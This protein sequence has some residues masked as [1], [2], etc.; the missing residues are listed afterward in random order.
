MSNNVLEL[1]RRAA[2]LNAAVQTRYEGVLAGRLAMKEYNGYVDKADIELKDIAE[3]IKSIN[4]GQKWR[5]GAAAPNADDGPNWPGENSGG[6][7]IKRFDA[8]SPLDASEAEWFGMFSAAQKRLGGF[9]TRVGQTKSKAMGSSDL[10]TKAGFGEGAPGTLLPAILLPDAYRLPY[11]PDRLFG[12]F[13]GEA[14]ES[15]WVS[16]LMHS[17]NTGAPTS[18]G[19]LQPKP[20]L[21]MQVTPMTVEFTVIAVLQSFSLQAIRDFSD[22]MSFAPSE[23]TRAVVNE[24]TNQIVNGTGSGSDMVGILATPGVL[25]RHPGMDSP[26]DTPVDT[27]VKAINDIRVG[28]GFGKADLIAMHPSTWTYLRTQKNS[29]GSYLL[30][31]DS[32][33][34]LGSMNDLFGVSVVENTLIPVGTAI[35]FDTTNSVKS[36]TRWGLEIMLNQFGDYEFANNAVTWRCEERV[37][38]GVYRPSNVCVVSGLVPGG[39]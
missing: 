4:A 28:P 37:A 25:T 8:P 14:A 3:Q 31:Q 12:S 39:S 17:G 13:P 19:E 29:Y 32:P 27:V 30:M 26:A 15:Q 38:I 16:Y 9:T 21:G 18:V 23:L 33:N 24:E 5:A 34:K 2:E 22:F 1:K 7:R 11:E 35:V 10:V 6:L 36:W 20:Q